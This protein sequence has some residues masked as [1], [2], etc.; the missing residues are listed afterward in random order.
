MVAPKAARRQRLALSLRYG[1]D[2]S[3]AGVAQVMRISEPAAK[4]LLA[5]ARES[6]RQALANETNEV[7]T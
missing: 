6:L 3:T 5:R 1:A 7:G 2:L 4:Q